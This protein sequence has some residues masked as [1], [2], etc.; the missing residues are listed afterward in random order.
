MAEIRKAIR[1][2]ATIAIGLLVVSVIFQVTGIAL[3]SLNAATANISSYVSV[4]SIATTVNTLIP[5]VD[6]VFI[7]STIV[8]LLELFGAD[9]II[10]IGL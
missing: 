1:D 2:L 6:L 4:A 8:V 5:I 9:Q 10:N 3:S 7:I